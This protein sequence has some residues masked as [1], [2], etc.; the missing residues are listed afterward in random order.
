[1]V[2]KSGSG[3]LS[4][5]GSAEGLREESQTAEGRDIGDQEWVGVQGAAGPVLTLH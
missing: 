3:D 4:V 5:G 1:M 2:N